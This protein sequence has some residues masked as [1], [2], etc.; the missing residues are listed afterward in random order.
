MKTKIFLIIIGIF[1]FGISW[2]QTRQIEGAVVDNETNTTIIGATIIQKGTTNGT[3]SDL[4]GNFKI[5]LLDNYEQVILVSYIGYE[6]SEIDVSSRNSVNVI[7]ELDNTLLDEVVIVGYGS[8]TLKDVTGSISTVNSKD[9]ENQPIPRIE[10]MLQGRVNGVEVTQNSGAP[11][12]SISIRIRGTSSY[13]ASSSPLYVIDGI[14]GGDINTINPNDIESITVLKDASANAIYGAFAANGVVVVTT[15]RGKGGKPKLDVNFTQGL[16]HVSRK[17][18][19]MNAPEYMMSVKEKQII[20]DA[21]IDPNNPNDPKLIFTDNDIR[22]A[23]INGNSTD[24]QNEIFQMAQSNNIQLSLSG[25]SDTDNY[26]LSAGYNNAEG[27]VL[28]TDY[29]RANIRFKYSSNLTDK[30]TLG[31]NINNDFERMHNASRSS[32]GNTKIIKSMLGYAPTEPVYLEDNTYSLRTAGY[33]YITMN[34][35]V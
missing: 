4:D 3:I 6:S 25:G 32:G 16:S 34:N 28:N 27:I 21:G 35:P 9:F 23:L 7:L 22:E 8:Q 29:E 10:N 12:A 18:D 30:L 26:Y 13:A 15:K 19:L 5:D 31:L 2:S 17:L 24:W 11:G 33:G 14:I 20:T 1:I